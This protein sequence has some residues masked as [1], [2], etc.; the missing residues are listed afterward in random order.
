MSAALD[1][2]LFKFGQLHP[3]EI[4]LSLGRIEQL[5]ERLG[6]PQRR[7]PP[8][9]HVA[10]TNGK[11]STVAFL[12]SCL[13]AA[14]KRVHVYTSPHLVRF[15]ERIRLNGQ[16][17]DDDLLVS[18]LRDVDAINGDA[19]ITFFEIITA[20]AL[21]VFARVPA[22][23][24][25]LE[26]GMGGR[27]D[28]TN[29]IDRP[30]ACGI[31]QLALDHQQFLGSTLTA[32]A[33]EKA[34]IAKAGR[35]LVHCTYPQP[36][37]Q[38]VA[39]IAMLTKSKLIV[40][41]A[42]WDCASYQD[43]LH[44]RDAQGKLA[45]P[46]PKLAGAFQGDNA[47]LAIAMLRHQQ[48]IVVPEAAFRAGLGWAEWPARLQ[49]ISQGPLRSLAPEGSKLWLDGGHNP[50]AAKML[51]Q[52]FGQ[53]AQTDLPLVVIIGM[54]AN[55]DANSFIKAFTGVAQQII[56]VPLPDDS[57]AYHQPETLVSYANAA[58]LPANQA[59][60]VQDALRLIKQPSRVLICGSLYL[61][62]DVLRLS[63]LAPQ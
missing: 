5:L 58:G 38:R 11:G 49:P 9:F 32:I 25:V 21:L 24:V 23:A 39:E 34:G 15:Q 8:V 30:A 47:G 14:G 16:L 17:I 27:F 45:L 57:H 19:P 13:E 28:A 53:G 4:D 36:V 43:Q 52:H 31:A 6:Q 46:T 63:G 61:A 48:D 56:A 26:V 50:A 3:R 10:G 60:S 55:K 20:A 51:A 54:L 1:Q 29:V 37:M 40:R 2:L 12:R 7:L 62:G 59:P 33:A 22:D 35:P 42:D 41:G 18:L 44:Y